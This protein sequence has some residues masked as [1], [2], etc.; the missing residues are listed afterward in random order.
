MTV[1]N[2]LNVIADNGILLNLDNNSVTQASFVNNKK[3]DIIFNNNRDLTLKEVE[4]KADG[5]KINII[6]NGSV[7]SEN[8]LKSNGNIFIWSDKDIEIQKDSSAKNWIG[9]YAENGGI[10]TKSLTG[11][12]I[13]L[14]AENNGLTADNILSDSYIKAD[15]KQGDITTGNL[16][17]S[18]NDL[19]LITQDGNIS[20]KVIE[21]KKDI[22]VIAYNGNLE[23][24]S[25]INKDG[26]IEAVGY[27]SLKADSINASRNFYVGSLGDVIVKSLSAGLSFNAIISDLFDD[28]TPDK[29]ASYLLGKNIKIDSIYVANNFEAKVNGKFNVSNILIG[30][31]ANIT[32][33]NDIEIGSIKS[34]NELD[35]TSHGEGFININDVKVDNGT[36]NISNE[37]GNIELNTLSTGGDVHVSNG[38]EGDIIVNNLNI[39]N[40]GSFYSNLNAGFL[41]LKSGSIDGEASIYS[42]KGAVLLTKI[43]VGKE[44]DVIAKDGSIIIAE[45]TLIGGDADLK[46]DTESVIL[47]DADVVGNMKISAKDYSYIV[48][49]IVG[50][51]MLMKG[52][53]VGCFAQSLNVG[54]DLIL[55]TN[56]GSIVVDDAKVGNN[57]YI[58]IDGN[59]KDI[60]I[61]NIKS[62]NDLNGDLIVVSHSKMGDKNNIS[63]KNAVAGNKLIINSLSNINLTN[64]FAL[65]GKLEV[66]AGGDVVADLIK[67]AKDTYIATLTGLIKIK[68]LISGDKISISRFGNLSNPEEGMIIEYIETTNPDADINI[69]Q[70]IGSAKIS[71]ASS[72][73][74]LEFTT[75]SGN[76]ELN[77]VSA[78]RDIVVNGGTLFLGGGAD[79]NISDSYA[80]NNINLNGGKGEVNVTNT[81]IGNDFNVYLHGP[82]NV[83]DVNV[84]NNSK[85]TSYY[86]SNASF[87]RFK[88]GSLEFNDKGESN[89][90]FDNS[91]IGK[92]NIN[93]S[94]SFDFAN[95]SAK[96]V[97]AVL[98]G[99]SRITDSE[100]GKTDISN[101]SELLLENT[102]GQDIKLTNNNN[103]KVIKDTI[104]SL[105]L[106]NNSQ[107]ITEDSTINSMTATNNKNSKLELTNNLNVGNMN[108]TN[109]G[110]T[111]IHN[112]TIDSA[113][114]LNE[115]QFE[116]TAAPVNNLNFTN[117]SKG[118]ALIHDNK[119][120]SMSVSNDGE[121][122]IINLTGETAELSSKGNTNITDS[123]IA[124]ANL[125]VSAG[126]TNIDNLT[127][128]KL[129][130]VVSGKSNISNSSITNYDLSN[131]GETV[132]KDSNIKTMT[133]TN[134]GDLKVNKITGNKLVLASKGTT[135][136]EDSNINNINADISGKATINE[137]KSDKLELISSGNTNID[138]S[139][140]T[141][142]NANLSGNTTINNLTNS[143]MSFVNSGNT[144]ISKTSSDKFDL[145]NSGVSVI[146][147]SNINTVTA[148]NDGNLELTT[149]PVEYFD[150][151]NKSNGKAQIHDITVTSMTASNDGVL[152]G[153]TL[154]SDK[155][156]LT[157][158]GNT[159]IGNSTIKA[160]NANNSG[161]FDVKELNS[162]KLELT[163]TGDTSIA[164]STIININANISGDANINNL[165]GNLMSYVISGNVKLSNSSTN[166]ITLDNT[167]KT[168]LNNLKVES[169]AYIV[170]NKGNMDMD[171]LNVANNFDLDSKSGSIN[172]SGI[173]ITNDFNFA[174]KGNSG[175]KFEDITIGNDFNVYA[176]K[177][178]LDGSTLNVGNDLHT[179]TYSKYSAPKA[180]SRA[181]VAPNS[182]SGKA[183]ETEEGFTLILD[184]LNI[185]GGLYVNN[186]D[187]TIKVQESN[188]GHDVNID[189]GKEKI[190]IDK[191][192][193]DGGSLDIKGD[194]G[195]I[196][197]GDVNVDNETSVKLGNG[198]LEVASLTSTLGVDFNVGGNI[199]SDQ[200]IKTENS[201]VNAVAG[202]NI[203]AST[204]EAK[205]NIDF[206]AGGSIVSD[207]KIET[208]T[209]SVNMVA[210]GSVDAYKVLAQQQGNIEA[211]N[212]DIIIGQINGKTLVFKQDTNDKTLRIRE[213]NVETK[214]TAGADYIDID[215]INHKS[216]EVELGI[217][218][219]LVNGRAMDNV[220]IGDV[221]TDQGVN[222]FNLVSTYGDIHVSNEIF[223]L[224]KTYLLKRGDLSNA[225]IKFRL[226]G[227]NPV[228]SK[229]ADIIAFFSPTKNHKDFANISFTNEWGPDKQDYYP[230]TAK[231]D[232]K[233]MFN[234]YTVVQEYETIRLAYEERIKEINDDFSSKLEYLKLDYN[235]PYYYGESSLHI[236]SES[237]N[238]DEI[239]IPLSVEF[240]SVSGELKPAGSYEKSMVAKD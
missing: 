122:N 162:D 50:G 81:S 157:N 94:G 179:Y 123:K 143:Q 184:E 48:N 167:G 235:R 137:L 170:N 90:I 135:N 20:S 228:Y 164:D 62:G 46:S 79:I 129:S 212:G 198:N 173:N 27:K 201:T 67:A 71:N 68:H 23:V 147:D 238:L 115:G 32:G 126:V 229:E 28:F 8:G 182:G 109:K 190:K 75:L 140:I 29:L 206:N 97:T 136:I 221:K 38:T 3:G 219:T 165:V 61:G 166:K 196:K 132:I 4:N 185:G 214:I 160:I 40:A 168:N 36:L 169:N 213:A 119:V 141:N 218:F 44:L 96:D 176:G 151:T 125:N 202:G 124:N 154:T 107:A 43:L 52:D 130:S 24:N 199:T 204:V 128:S 211:V 87:N 85:I 149:T 99:I 113:V 69:I 10:K 210:G 114:A 175:V 223:N 108:L 100:L 105:N 92:G 193:V 76:I 34:G 60:S 239:D 72:A 5:A 142:F 155:L 35:I 181:A 70:G 203:T 14:S 156:D 78:G 186:P 222:M 13:D 230:L 148:V 104:N 127:S 11:G 86:N 197:L 120:N 74:D 224:T 208:E 49:A 117:K 180:S 55:N 53:V 232:Y 106:I 21:A 200:L 134:D 236:D 80:G 188:V 83:A 110:N 102:N 227:D 16:T 216:D 42:E 161:K 233:R 225:K 6:N 205:G 65:N 158:S 138:N 19:S 153:N 82:M 15:I 37:I 101:N 112:S 56:T 174:L 234:Q 31:K 7:I 98:N 63:I 77:K 84:G 187:V 133:T 116:L 195:A 146:K 220:V 57:S 103:L 207:N 25:I 150:L 171:Q 209:E 237:V 54:K 2:L 18:E 95:S 145:T 41:N 226:Y 33:Q 45:K 66:K 22:N 39:K 17:A 47:S 240:D 73:R 9:L 231:N 64:A 215:M 88:T 58:S 191:L 12:S 172:M 59:G 121:L 111:L 194:S 192:D 189:A 26:D 91:E 163:S 89:V 139:I 217:D 51:S 1:S 30:K 177:A 178:V 152:D 144:T 93:I 183:S 131:N 118:N 159:N